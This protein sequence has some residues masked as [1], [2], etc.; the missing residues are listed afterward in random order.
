MKQALCAYHPNAQRNRLP[1]RF[2]NEAKPYVRFCQARNVST[3]KC[4]H[5]QAPHAQAPVAPV[6]LAVSHTCIAIHVIAV[7]LR[8]TRQPATSRTARRSRTF[9]TTT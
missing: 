7:H 2:D 1:T 8:A 4:A 5:A 6:E 3:F 9:S